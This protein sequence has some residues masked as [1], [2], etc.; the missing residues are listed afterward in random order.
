M[1]LEAMV[2]ALNDSPV[3]DALERLTL[4]ALADHAR[5]DG[6]GAFPSKATIA[7]RALSDP[8]TIQR[9]LAELQRRGLIA[10]GDQS[11]ARHIEP[12]YRPVVYDLLIPYSWFS[13]I[14]RTNADRMRSGRPAL[15]P[16][17]RPEIAPPPEKTRRSDVGKPRK[18]KAAK[19]PAEPGA[20]S[21]EDFQSPLE[22]DRAGG[23]ESPGRG[24]CQSPEGGLEDPQTKG[25]NRTTKPPS[26]RV[27][28]HD[29][30]AVAEETAEGRGAKQS[31]GIQEPCASVAQEEPGPV[32]R[33][34]AAALAGAPL[35]HVERAERIAA[36]V[37]GVL[38]RGAAE[39]DL[40]DYL[41]ADRAG[42]R[43]VA[44]VVEY[45]LAAEQLPGALFPAAG[46]GVAPVLAVVE[47]CSAC[48]ANRCIDVEDESGRPMVKRCPTCHP[49]ALAKKA[50]E[51]AF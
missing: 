38:S 34:L 49:V 33:V 22:M 6:C 5:A 14:E 32:D 7:K 46:P 40:L 24:D 20:Q 19:A 8:K 28:E 39:A 21:R 13:N 47:K 35:L 16:Q 4:M 23:T 51:P 17:S 50:L 31:T 41:T 15:T 26:Q 2:W 29:A 11:E 43:S 36:L 9:K 27:A 18:T 1:S 44:S 45:R 10:P 42:A 37:A 48:D 12:R 30:E 25:L 3:A